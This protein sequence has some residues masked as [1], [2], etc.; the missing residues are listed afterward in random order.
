MYLNI[1]T[2]DSFKLINE[3]HRV[4]VRDGK[5][6]CRVPNMISP[7]SIFSFGDITHLSFFSPNSLSQLILSKSF[8]RIRMNQIQ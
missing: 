8:N 5:F 4:L 6:I 1:L 7:F 2:N 3:I